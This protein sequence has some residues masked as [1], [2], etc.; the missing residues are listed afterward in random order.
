MTKRDEILA[1]AATLAA[2]EGLG[3]LSVRA[4]A[5]EAGVGPTT[6]RNYFPSQSNLMEALA[7]RLVTDVLMDA[8]LGEESLPAAERLF[9]ALE[10]FLPTPDTH[11]DAL[12]GW[13]ELYSL[14]LGTRSIDGVHEVVRSGRT[15]SVRTLIR[16]YETLAGQGASLTATPERLAHRTLAFVDGLHLMLLMER[17]AIDL[18]GA[19][20]D[21][22]WFSRSVFD[23]PAE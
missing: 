9:S 3:Q 16:W 8:G 7:A 21:L 23:N 17:D 12:A 10:Q 15:E 14:S 22:R 20:N 19:R 6:L 13:S 11:D 2:R 4:V 1:A 5:A 18:A